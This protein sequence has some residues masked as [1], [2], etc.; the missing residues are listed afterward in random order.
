VPLLRLRVLIGDRDPE[1][2]SDCLAAMLL[3]D[4]EGP[5]FEFVASHLES[6]EPENREAAALAL[7]ESRLPEAFP[8]LRQWW[9]GLLDHEERR[10]ALLALALL[11]REPAR[12]LLTSLVEKAPLRTALAAVEALRLFRGD[13]RVE[14]WVRAAAEARS[15]VKDAVETVF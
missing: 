2:I 7:G 14:E 9:D 8:V 10:T 15:E 13:Q 12:D 4:P 5:S 1:V 11:R 6:A 3:L